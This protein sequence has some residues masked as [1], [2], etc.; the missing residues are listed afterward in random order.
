MAAW[1]PWDPNMPSSRTRA[2]HVARKQPLSSHCARALGSPSK[3]PSFGSS[4]STVVY[5][6]GGPD[7]GL[8]REGGRV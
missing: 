3:G 5:S 1:T 2:Q 8:G 4:V 6:I 7:V